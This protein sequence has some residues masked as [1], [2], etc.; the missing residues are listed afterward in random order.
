VTAAPVAVRSSASTRVRAVAKASGA[1]II[2]QLFA[3]SLYVFPSDSV[4]RAIGA[5]GYVASLVGLFALGVWLVVVAMGLHRP[6]EV[7][8]P[9]RVPL[10]AL[11]TVGLISYYFMNRREH[12]E[13]VLLAADRWLIM[14]AM[15]TG[16]V[17]VAAEGLRS[18]EDVKRV[19][20]VVVAAGSFAG[21]VAAMQFWFDFDLTPTL[22]S[23]PGFTLNADNVAISARA[24]VARVA[25][26]AIH[27]I[28]LGVVAGM[29]LPLAVFLAMHDTHR[30]ALWRW[31]PVACIGV[32]VP[33]SVSR[34]GVIAALLAITIFIVLLPPVPRLYGFAIVPVVLLGIYTAVPN[35]VDTLSSYFQAGTN[36]LSVATRVDDYPLVVKLVGH[37]PFFGQGG[38]SYFPVDAY[39]IFDNEFFKTAVELG[40]FGLA[41]LLV[42]LAAP[43][44]TSF[45]ARRRSDD[46]EL[47]TLCGALAG[48][49]AAGLVC[50]ATFDSFSFPMFV[51]TE[52]LVVGLSAC[53][54]RL[55][56]KATT[57][58]GAS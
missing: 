37:H 26:T 17:L 44:I 18:L 57:A 35:V 28:E 20:R 21:I 33:V 16:I 53:V 11:W 13:E 31:L 5:N 51:G 38:G 54:W 41:A 1:I 14:L 45:V 2:L 19:L 15:V 46:L 4:I 40:L 7:K 58:M 47:R 8:H 52:A 32:A 56:S 24:D 6:G 55:T 50:S 10:L 3:I 27:P 23:L 29:L 9:A 34:S 25:G 12:T 36:D 39:Q 22:R 30:R 48:A 42:F 49:G 43:I